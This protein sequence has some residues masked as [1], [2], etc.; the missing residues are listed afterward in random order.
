MENKEFDFKSLAPQTDVDLTA[1]E[2][3]LKFAL[4]NES[5]KNVAITGAYG[6]G[7]SS[8]METFKNTQYGKQYKYLHI[9]LA[10]FEKINPIKGT[11]STEEQVVHQLEG[12]IIN[13]LVH[14]IPVENIA[15]SRVSLRKKPNEESVMK[16]TIGIMT[17]IIISLY[18]FFF[19]SMLAVETNNLFLR[20]LCRIL[21]KQEVLILIIIIAVFLIYQLIR[22][23]VTAQMKNRFFRKI[24][25]KD[26]EIEMFGEDKENS[27]SYFDRYLDE[28]KYLLRNADIDVFVFEDIDRYNTNLIFEKLREINSIVNVG[29]EKP[30]RFFYLVRDD[31]FVQK[32]RTKFFD[33]IIP[34]LPIVSGHNSFDVFFQYMG[35]DGG[36]LS[37]LFLKQISLYIDDMRIL[38]NIYNEYQIYVQKYKGISGSKSPEKIFSLVTYKNLF[39]EDFIRLQRGEGYVKALFKVKKALADNEVEKMEKQIIESEKMEKI[40]KENAELTI[41]KD[42]KELDALFFRL[43][44]KYRCD[45]KE[46]NEYVSLS[47][48]VSGI[49]SNPEKVERYDDFYSEWENCESEIRSLISNMEEDDEYK[50]RREEIRRKNDYLDSKLSNIIYNRVALETERDDLKNIN[51]QEYVSK[52]GEKVLKLEVIKGDRYNRKIQ[53]SLYSELIHFLLA[54]GYID[55]NYA[56]YMVVFHEGDLVLQD[57]KYVRAVLDNAELGYLYPIQNPSVVGE[58]LTDKNL[59]REAVLNLSMFEHYYNKGTE[60]QKTA[61]GNAICQKKA[62]DFI[63]LLLEKSNIAFLEWIDRINTIWR[64]TF[65]YIKDSSFEEQLLSLFSAA[66][67]FS[68]YQ[69]LFKYHFV[70]EEKEYILN[71]VCKDSSAFEQVLNHDKISGGARVRFL[72]CFKDNWTT[73]GWKMPY[74]EFDMEHSKDFAEVVYYNNFYEINLGMI[75][76]ILQKWYGIKIDENETQL[77]D[78]IVASNNQGKEPT[79]LYLYIYNNI[80]LY[81]DMVIKSN[82]EV[83][84]SSE[85]LAAMVLAADVEHQEML[86][87]NMQ[88]C[89]EGVTEVSHLNSVNRLIRHGKLAYTTKN[90]FA[91]YDLY[92][93]EKKELEIKGMELT[94]DNLIIKY[95]NDFPETEIYFGQNEVQEYRDKNEDRISSLFKLFCRC[96]ELSDA[97]YR[98]LTKGLHRVWKQVAPSD[99]PV[100]KMDI[101][102]EENIIKMTKEVL[103]GMREKYPNHVKKYILHNVDEYVNDVVDGN[104]FKM[105]ECMM[106]LGES[107]ADEYKMKILEYTPESIS[108]QNSRYSEQ[109]VLYIL[110]NNYDERDFTHIITH[111]YQNKDLQQ[112]IIEIAENEIDEIVDNEYVISK[113]L[114]CH[115]L[116]KSTDVLT[117]GQKKS[118]FAQHM[119]YFTMDEVF[120][121]MLELEMDEYRPLFDKK[122]P[123]VTQSEI[124]R[125]LLTSLNHSGLIGVFKESESDPGYYRVYAKKKV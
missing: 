76:Q 30:I 98:S 9:S 17:G 120:N 56:D 95:V 70:R 110:K 68:R 2:E 87:S 48:F 26:Y 99:I 86:I 15:D 47:E 13:Q 125:K 46:R 71:V 66:M 11:L 81:I 12:K 28:I 72:E 107:I 82:I 20:N 51:Y 101:L 105:S 52:Y 35:K 32:D 116:K 6:A 33:F 54:N 25:V 37:R 78:K 22:Y 94:S 3:A 16:W 89:I 114:C 102:I 34:I 4:S 29:Q 19:Q 113:M 57:K 45:G 14:K 122:N 38:K 96:N 93:D 61:L 117:V 123:L 21:T 59:E 50:T 111:E 97:K 31:L 27:F 83:C 41:L 90:I 88:T 91:Y 23:L 67:L 5:V 42:Y 84:D 118:I 100:D 79:P 69:Y 103:P 55:E 10:H 77:W 80:N 39:P 65:E 106:L 64:G 85:N 62:Y 115:L 112:Y 7:K 49:I 74:F 109:L 119:K 24:C 63:C 8:V 92:I 43:D 44:G 1:Y 53:N 75:K 18:F 108:V 36:K 73:L 121:I 58:Y 40:E 104:N 124:N 60:T